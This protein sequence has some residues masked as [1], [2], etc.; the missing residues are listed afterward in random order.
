M[1]RFDIIN[2]R[3]RKN[4]PIFSGGSGL[5]V[6]KELDKFLSICEY[7]FQSLNETAEEKNI[8][9][10]GIKCML[11]GDAYELMKLYAIKTYPEF[12][13]VLS[14]AYI[15]KKTISETNREL[16]N[17][18][19]LTQ[20]TTREYF[21]RLRGHLQESKNLLTEKY[22]INNE[23]LLS[24][25]E[26]QACII[27]KRGTKNIGLRNYLLDNSAVTLSDLESVAH[28]YEE[29]ERELWGEYVR[30]EPKLQHSVVNNHKI[31]HIR[32]ESVHNNYSPSNTQSCRKQCKNEY[33]DNS[34]RD[35]QIYNQVQLSESNN[36]REQNYQDH[37][38]NQ[39]QL[40][41]QKNY[42]K[43]ITT[44]ENANMSVI[45]N[46]SKIAVCN[47]CGNSGHIRKNCALKIKK[48]IN[49]LN[50]IQQH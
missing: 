48:N 13:K 5:E 36:N 7:I 34:Y 44:T 8:F 45:R 1:D 49:N 19:Q 42:R 23:A 38:L 22:P 39:D 27:F 46:E 16:Y 21:R 33:N 18:V 29:A 17:C 30:E 40:N 2:R 6:S 20:E 47:L 10:S 9:L 24:N 50:I 15:R 14:N 3:I 11:Y 41:T 35:K 12:K 28:T 4:I 32:N 43:K 37:N 25:Q 31:N 26:L